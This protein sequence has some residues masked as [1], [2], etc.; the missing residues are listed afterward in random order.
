MADWLTLDNVQ[1]KGKQ[2][3]LLSAADN[4]GNTYRR[5]KLAV[6]DN[7]GN[8]KVVNVVQYN[9]PYI[10]RIPPYSN[11]NGAGGECWITVKCAYNWWWR[12]I[13][14][15]ITIYDYNGNVVKEGQTL[16]ATDEYGRSYRFVAS[17]NT[18][19]A[20][21]NT[22]VSIGCRRNDNN[23]FYSGGI[24]L[25]QDIWDGSSIP[26]SYSLENASIENAPDS[27]SSGATFSYTL[28][29]DENYKVKACTVQTLSGG[30]WTEVTGAYDS[31]TGVISFTV[32]ACEEV[33]ISSTSEYT[34]TYIDNPLYLTLADD[35]Y[36]IQINLAY[37][38]KEDLTV[39]VEWLDEDNTDSETVKILAGK[40]TAVMNLSVQD[41]DP[42]FR[43]FQLQEIYMN[44][45]VK[46]YY[47]GQYRVYS[48]KDF[49][50]GLTDKMDEMGN[51]S[52]DNITW[53]DD[54]RIAPKPPVPDPLN[55]YINLSVTSI[56]YT[57]DSGS[58][59]VLVESNITWEVTVP[60]WVKA[61]TLSG[62]GDG[63]IKISADANIGFDRSG[64]ITVYNT[65][66][67]ITK[68]IKIS[69]EGDANI[70]LTAD[71]TTLNATGATATI[72]VQVN[73]SDAWTLEATAGVTLSATSG[74]GSGT[75]TATFA[76]NETTSEKNYTV[77][78]KTGEYS[79]TVS[80]TQSASEKPYINV[81]TTS[82]NVPAAGGTSSVDI[83]ANVC[84]TV[85]EYSEP[86]TGNTK[87]YYT[88]TNGNVVTPTTLS[89]TDAEGNKLTYT[90]T[91][92]DGQGIIEFS[93]VV[94]ELRMQFYG[95][96]TLKTFDGV[97]NKVKLAS[98]A[99][100]MFYSCNALTSLDVSNFDTSS[101]TTME[102][103]FYGCGSLTSLDV[104]NFN[105]SSVT[106][107]GGMFY[108]CGSLT[109]LD[110]SN[111]N[112][113]SVIYMNGMFSDC[114]K[115][116]SL[117][118]SNFD[119]K[120]VT[121]MYSM[122]SDCSKLTSLDVSNFNTSSVTDMSNMFNNCSS[123]TTLDVSNF[124]TSKVTNMQSMFNRCSGLTSLDL[125][126]WD[127]SSVTNMELMFY[128]CSS[129]TSLDV[130]NFDTSSVIYMYEM[131]GSC[132]ALRT[133]D[134]SN[135]NTSKATNMNYMFEYCSNLTTLKI[136]SNC[137]IGS[138]TATTRM[139]DGL[140]L[141][142]I[143]YYPSGMDSTQVEKWTPS[144]K[145]TAVAY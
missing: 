104:R 13:P 56:G 100:R 43:N 112:T 61:D 106:N 2:T 47:S 30:T 108:D 67:G 44:G 29:A 107:M 129:L 27:I 86:V 35:G 84:W 28:V 26:I 71:K 25:T 48:S 102:Y 16:S 115:L 55:Y 123:L 140:Y 143:L 93:G 70:L 9:R 121:A 79:S 14:D 72:T 94:E 118:L 131:F 105:T 51:T 95:I 80:F 23:T 63:V 52:Y 66:Y 69:Q 31:S 109:S 124:N 58:T 113:S 8:T 114:S 20:S 50:N 88:S 62:N 38:L 77:T 101:V 40:K 142:G 64:T 117:D 42:D 89:A 119:T 138:D 136:G 76:D 92:S 11:L 81:G 17:K 83:D 110:V 39:V 75:V 59:S 99:S 74:T 34:S 22:T 7:A 144:Y 32:P 134:V 65:S 4:T 41:L 60:S 130:S 82:V 54:G 78:G 97:S 21:R 36:Y 5:V 24:T 139:F 33:K 98:D 6:K 3:V 120:S 122:F 49:S 135:F 145:W 125:N 37:P 116:T 10:Q 87:I 111:F 1:G 141:S 128:G 73:S 53:G 133:L 103:M 132:K 68:T 45:A 90:N 91:Y 85:E 57:S 12:S 96:S 19:D 126:N 15:W 18:T 137:T 46:E 127:T